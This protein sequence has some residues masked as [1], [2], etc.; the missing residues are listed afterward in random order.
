MSAAIT[1]G[2]MRAL[3]RR[4]FDMTDETSLTLMENA[5]RAVFSRAL[6]F[7]ARRALFVCGA[8]NNGADGLAAARLYTLSGREA[9]VWLIG[10]SGTE[11]SVYQKE[12]LTRQGVPIEPYSL[13]TPVPEG[14][15][16][17][18][19]ALFGIG[20]SRA[21]SGSA[22]AAI[23]AMNAS[24]LPI[25]S[26]DIPSGLNAD[27]GE[28]MGACVR[29]TET[30]SLHR[31]KQGLLL[32]RGQ[33]VCGKLTVC[34][35]GIPR[36]LDDF[37]GLSVLLPREITGLIKPRAR[38]T[39]KGDYGRVT[40]LCGSVGMAGAAGISALAALK[41]GAGLVKIACPPEITSA[42][43]AIC[44]CATCAPITDADALISAIKGADAIAAGCGLGT[45]A[46]ARRNLTVLLEYVVNTDAR[47]VLD[48]DAL[49]IIARMPEPPKLTERQ[50]ITPHPAEAARLLGCEAADITRDPISAARRLN[51]KYGCAA[52]VKGA[53]TAM[54]TKG[55][56]AVNIIGTPAMAKGG[57]GDALT[58][59]LAAIL[60]KEKG[61]D[62]LTAMQL[63]CGLN[64]MAARRAAEYHGEN[65]LLATE[66]CES[67]GRLSR[68]SARILGK[69]VTVTVD[70]PLGSAHP[71]KPDILY[72]VN[73]GYVAGVPADDGSWQDA[74]ILGVSEP[75]GSF[76]GDVIAVI[77]RLDDTEDKWIVAPKGLRYTENEIWES[78]RFVEQFFT[79]KIE[80]IREG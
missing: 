58:G 57:S 43:Q 33:D 78:T 10:D 64:G 54:A 80:V 29:A 53:V 36:E 26:I 37:A 11:E 67:I 30:V 14:C 24:S 59:T 68:S 72:T 46:E 69:T 41:T 45:G 71:R 23:E 42:V 20:L 19:D 5:A 76:T 70:R 32:G 16:L 12:L 7:P 55:G 3:E 6:A 15:G 25:L 49:N 27:T 56:A 48:A 1:K 28:I 40:L 75:I 35:I 74:Y 60:G 8:G 44:P 13:D 73:Y 52:L 61:M 38:D 39:H 77:H 65:G 17:I 50:I 21:V 18:V 62:A 34:N 4:V 31:I 51:E 63:A 2:D 22:L 9:I 66:L 79:G 47:C